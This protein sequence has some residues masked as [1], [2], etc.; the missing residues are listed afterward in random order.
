MPRAGRAAGR[1]AARGADGRHRRRLHGGAARG[2]R[3]RHRRRRALPDATPSPDSRR[4]RRARAQTLPNE[5]RSNAC[6]LQRQSGGRRRARSTGRTSCSRPAATTTTAATGTFK[7]RQRSSASPSGRP[8]TSCQTGTACNEPGGYGPAGD[9]GNLGC[10]AIKVTETT[11]VQPLFMQILGF[12]GRT[13]PRLRHRRHRGGPH[14]PRRGDDRRLDRI[15]AETAD[16]CW[17]YRRMFESVTLAGRLAGPAQVDSPLASPC[18][19][20]SAVA[21]SATGTNPASRSTR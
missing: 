19:P 11:S 2:P 17:W 3:T 21:T 4:L 13:S 20:R 5:Q 14:T 1:G 8:G 7:P 16:T 9:A 15:D 10:N 6:N 12:G 18:Q